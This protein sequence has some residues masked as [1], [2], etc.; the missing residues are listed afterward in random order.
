MSFTSQTAAHASRVSSSSLVVTRTAL[1]GSAPESSLPMAASLGD[2]LLASP[3]NAAPMPGEHKASRQTWHTHH[4]HDSRPFDGCIKGVKFRATR[5][6]L[7]GC[8]MCCADAQH[9]RL[10]KAFW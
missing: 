1:L 6:T 4:T 9:M 2:G 7:F 5:G 3:M 8:M 10:P